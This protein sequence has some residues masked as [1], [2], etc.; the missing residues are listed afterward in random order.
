M[1]LALNAGS[2][3]SAALRSLMRSH[4]SGVSR[5]PRDGNGAQC[6][7][8]RKM[9]ALHRDVSA[10]RPSQAVH[11]ENTV[12]APLHHVTGIG[13]FASWSEPSL[14]RHGGGARPSGV[15]LGQEARTVTAATTTK[16][17][18]KSTAKNATTAKAKEPKVATKQAESTATAKPTPPTSIADYIATLTADEQRYARKAWRH[19]TGQRGTA[20][21]LRGITKEQATVIRERIGQLVESE[22]GGAR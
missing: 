15:T 4:C 13:R 10:H 14:R 3:Q 18:K 19:A 16:P 12:H 20:P 21:S 2:S 8:P 6:A 11:T 22:K 17:A 1:T 5:W 9:D 7:P